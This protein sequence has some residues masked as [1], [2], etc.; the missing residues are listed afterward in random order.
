M[1]T[2]T[3]LLRKSARTQRPRRPL[4]KNRFQ[5]LNPYITSLNFYKY[6]QNS[7]KAHSSHQ[8]GGDS[9]KGSRTDSMTFSN[10]IKNEVSQEPR[11]ASGSHSNSNNYHVASA[12]MSDQEFKVNQ[13]EQALNDKIAERERKESQLKDLN[14]FI[15]ELQE[16]LKLKTEENRELRNKINFLLQTQ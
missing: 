8:G 10:A 4:R 2:S 14:S 16:K 5:K 15:S 1:R 9:S 3:V 11:K 7:S 12:P 13:L 6:R